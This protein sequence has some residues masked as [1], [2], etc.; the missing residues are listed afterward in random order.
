MEFKSEVKQKLFWIFMYQDSLE[1]KTNRKIISV[2][3][4]C[5]AKRIFLR[6]D[7]W[8]LKNIRSN[9]IH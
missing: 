2:V 4:I 3:R 9:Q 1:I 6:K 5:F 7:N 8:K